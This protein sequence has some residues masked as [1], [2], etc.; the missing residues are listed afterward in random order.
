MKK[1]LSLIWAVLLLSACHHH[2]DPEDKTARRTVLVYMAAENNLVSFSNDD[3]DEMK[4]GSLLLNDDQNLIVYVDQAGS[5]TTPY[6]ARVKNGLLV[7]TLFMPEGIAADPTV[8]GRAVSN[9]RQYYPAKSYGLVLW[10]HASG[11]LISESDTISVAQSRAYGGST[12]NGSSSGSGKYWMNIPQMASSLSRAMGSDQFE[13]I[14]A[15]CCNMGCV[16]VAYELRD[17]TRYLIASPAEIPD[18][19]APYDL[20]VPDM[21]NE[22]NTFYRQLVDNYYSYY[23]DVYDTKGTSYYNRN[24]YDLRGYSVPLSV[25]DTQELDGLASA[26]A[27]LLATISDK[28]STTG[29]LALDNIVYYGLYGGYRYCYDASHVLQQNVST[30][31]FSTWKSA[32]DKAVPYHRY[33]NKWMTNYSSLMTA[34]ESF[35]TTEAEA[36]CVSMFFPGSTYR[37][38]SPN[39]NTAIQTY[40]WNSVIRWQQYGW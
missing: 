2:D 12:G 32:F 25:I 33:S 24:I 19:G 8:L 5:S 16:E 38:L 37:S 40:K 3:L 15:D 36:G 14:F 34:M 18:M 29:S 11:W 23:L 20:N 28:V 22:S 17:V 39:W 10:G 9:A 27:K 30:A 7:D 35:S 21:F 31:E 4:T 13:F 6:M 1:Y 26:T